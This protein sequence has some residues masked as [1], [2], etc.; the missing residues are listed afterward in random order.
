MFCPRSRRGEAGGQAS[1]PDQSSKNFVFRGEEKA[2]IL[3]GDLGLF[4]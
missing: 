1:G 2:Q 3:D 4:S